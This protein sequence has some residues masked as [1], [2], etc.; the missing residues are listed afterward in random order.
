MNIYVVWD[1]EIEEI[2][3]VAST[4]ELAEKWAD[5]ASNSY[6][7]F[8]V[9]NYEIDKPYVTG[10]C[11]WA[12]GMIAPNHNIENFGFSYNTI[13]KVWE[14]GPIPPPHFECYYKNDGL[15]DYEGY[16]F[17]KLNEYVTEDDYKAHKDELLAKLLER[18]QN[19]LEFTVP[20]AR[21]G[22]VAQEIERQLALALNREDI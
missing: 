1:T 12:S 13:P 20:Y 16:L 9:Y 14:P 6:N 11:I 2:A 19:A 5:S 21:E 17:I 15:T 4:L 22:V 3:Y 10:K 18:L 7:K 8:L